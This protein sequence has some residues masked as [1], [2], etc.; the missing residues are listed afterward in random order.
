MNNPSERIIENLLLSSRWLLVPLYLVLSLILI[1]FGAKA[2]QEFWHLATHLFELTESQ[3]VLATLSII[4]MT[5]VASLIVMVAL[6]GY[7]TFVSRFDTVNEM[8]KPS[9][10]GKLDPGTV[11]IKLAVS[12]VSISAI[13]LLK[14]YLSNEALDNARIYTLTA[15]HL[16]FVVSALLLAYLDKIAS[17]KAH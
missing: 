6:S 9:W 13:H 3:L 4:D 7:E 8:E 11:K 15:V 17:H 1:A 12:I 5:L 2:A 14:T 10:L 16:A